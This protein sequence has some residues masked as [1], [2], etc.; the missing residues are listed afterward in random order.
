LLWIESL[1]GTS[2]PC[3]REVKAGIEGQLQASELGMPQNVLVFQGRLDRDR[4]ESCV[5]AVGE[6]MGVPFSLRRTGN[7]TEISKAD[8][9]HSYL[10]WARDGSVVWYLER[11]MV[12]EV[13]AGTTSLRSNADVIALVHRVTPTDGYWMVGAVDLT[14]R[15]LG[16]PSRGYFVSADLR[17]RAVASDAPALVM[18]GS[19]VFAS[20]ADAA[21]AVARFTEV[22]H[23]PRFSEGL[24]QVLASTH[25]TASG[26]DVQFDALPLLAHADTLA[27]LVTLY[28]AA[29]PE[30]AR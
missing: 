23:D 2:P 1:P 30:V 15:L 9:G 10:G 25:P 21:L 3:V 19:F 26:S 18:S 8:G 11:A 4:V 14:Q 24:Q 13:L 7:I 5:Q 27:E 28:D 16:V 20:P 22:S 12:E 17:P 29:H 6:Q